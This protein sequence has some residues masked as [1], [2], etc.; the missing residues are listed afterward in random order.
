MNKIILDLS[1]SSIF[2]NASKFVEIMNSYYEDNFEIN[3]IDK[4]WNDIKFK[5]VVFDKKKGE[6]S[7]SDGNYIWDPSVHPS[8]FFNNLVFS[9]FE[10]LNF[11]KEISFFKKIL[12]IFKKNYISYNSCLALISDKNE[13]LSIEKYYL[14]FLKK[15]FS[16]KNFINYFLKIIEFKLTPFIKI[17]PSKFKPIK[18][19][20]KN[21]ENKDK[22]NK[23]INKYKN[24]KIKILI[25]V[26][27]DENKKFEV[28]ND[29]L[30]GGP[31]FKENHEED[32]EQL[33][34]FI[35][36]LDNQILSGKNYQFILASK[37][38]VDWENFLKSEY[39]D[40]RNFEELGFNLSE[41]IYIC[42]ELS[43]YTINW[44]STF[45]IWITN[46]KN[47]KHITYHDFKDTAVWCK[48]NL[49]NINNLI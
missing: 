14:D 43:N 36:K 19:R 49:N 21:I 1:T 29:R 32:F 16:F 3:I 18:Y 40:L 25:T 46:C 47:I 28:L 35:Q 23:F 39:I 33:K 30:K 12:Y 27:W 38:A 24:D 41:M 48:D 44:P 37:K 22:V 31:K 34:R 17:K 8:D 45:S 7:K 5:G 13:K 4:N 26:L 9:S 20:L 6:F 15:N 10:N 42:Q 11:L 2:A